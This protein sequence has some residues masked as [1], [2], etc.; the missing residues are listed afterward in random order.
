MDERWKKIDGR[1]ESFSDRREDGGVAKSSLSVCL[2]LSAFNRNRRL[3]RAQRS[4]GKLKPNF[5]N[6]SVTLGLGFN[7]RMLQQ[8]YH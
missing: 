1:V 4:T 8:W 3:S 6:F 5:I 7:F 2:S